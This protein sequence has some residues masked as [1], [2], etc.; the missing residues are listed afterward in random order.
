VSAAGFAAIPWQVPIVAASDFAAL[1]RQWRTQ[2]AL[3]QRALAGMAGISRRHLGFLERGLAAPSRDM[4]LRLATA[5]QV[6]LRGQNAWLLA[7]GLAPQWH[8]TDLSAPELAPLRRGIDHMLAQQEPFPAVVVDRHWNLLQANAGAVRFVEFFLGPLDPGAAINLADALVAPAILRPYLSNWEQ[9]VAHF[10]RSVELDA[11]ND[12]TVESAALL[13]RLSDYPGAREMLRRGPPIAGTEP[14]LP[15][16][17]QK[18]G[19]RISVFTA[20][21]T[22]G[23]PRHVTAQ[24]LRVESFFPVDDETARHMRSWAKAARR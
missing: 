16:H 17:F 9:V 14:V 24:E 1:L 11:A 6:P 12:G 21:A 7:A 2:R 22:L 18:G 5:L 15:M 20:I 23:T 4:V 3:S 8:E 19:V 13:R 10:L